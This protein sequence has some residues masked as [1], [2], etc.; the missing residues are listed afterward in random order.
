MTASPSPYIL[1]VVTVEDSLAIAERLQ[2]MFAEINYV[3]FLG[4][5]RNIAT[6][7]NL[8]DLQKPH[9]VIMDIYLEDDMPKANGVNLLVILKKKYPDL[10]I[11]MLTNLSE[12]QYRNTCVAFGADFFFDKTNEFDKIPGTLKALIDKKGA[13]VDNEFKKR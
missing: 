5:A 10:K 6:A 3:S 2:I 8:I 11:I 9:V 1:K 7:L 12:T 13:L 4:N